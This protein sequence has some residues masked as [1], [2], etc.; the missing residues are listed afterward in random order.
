MAHNQ[1]KTSRRFMLIGELKI[2][3]VRKGYF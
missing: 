2:D 3:G 1:M